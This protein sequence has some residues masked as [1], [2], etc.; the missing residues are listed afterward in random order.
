MK[1]STILKK[2]FSKLNKLVL[3]CNSERKTA[4]RPTNYGLHY[5]QSNGVWIDQSDISNGFNKM[6]LVRFCVGSLEHNKESIL[7]K[8]LEILEPLNSI[9]EK[10]IFQIISSGG[11]NYSHI[12]INV[13]LKNINNDES[14]L[15]ELFKILK[16]LNV[17]FTN[18]WNILD[19]KTVQSNLKLVNKLIKPWGKK[20]DIKLKKELLECNSMIKIR[21]KLTDI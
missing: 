11:N 15:T 18:T 13:D 14:E 4:P 3:D 10:G 2:I 8:V 17:K 19:L 16:F 9:K 20:I 5:S 12:K 1:T 21:Q 6:N 7:A